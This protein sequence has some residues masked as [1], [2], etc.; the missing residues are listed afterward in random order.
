M[1]VKPHLTTLMVYHR[2]RY[3]LMPDEGYLRITN[4]PL[5]PGM[6]PP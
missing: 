4:A 6:C 5:P 1:R 3:V 2:P